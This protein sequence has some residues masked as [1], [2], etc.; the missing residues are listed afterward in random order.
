MEFS[1]N[2][3]CGFEGGLQSNQSLTHLIFQAFLIL[4]QRWS[5]LLIRSL[6]F[7]IEETISSVP[8]GCGTKSCRLNLL[9]C[10]LQI[11]SCCLI[12]VSSKKQSNNQ[13]T[14]S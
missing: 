11:S 5:I 10:A 9:N 3:L 8:I 7:I 14:V 1:T 6:G 4:S 13:L 2:S 12:W